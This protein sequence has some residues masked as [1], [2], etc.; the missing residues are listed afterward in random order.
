MPIYMDRHDVPEKITAED[1]AQLHQEDL[2]IQD[3]FNCRVL[4][5]WFD[6]KRKNAFCLV[7][8]PDS[9]A[10]HEMHNHAHGEVPNRIIEVDA[11]IVE[12]F[13]G[14]IE[15]PEKEKNETLNIIREGAFRI[16]MVI[17]FKRSSPLQNADENFTSSL[18]HFS[19]KITDTL[20]AN[21]GKIVTQSSYHYL[22]SFT[23]ASN[24][25]H[26]ATGIQSLFK[27]DAEHN[28]ELKIGL[29][30]GLP[31]TKQPS[32]FEDAIKLAGRIC[33]IVKGEIIISSQVKELYENENADALSKA[34]IFSLT[35]ADENFITQ[36]MDYVDACWND[37]NL[38]VDDFSKPVHCSKSQ[39][40]RKL[41]A[42]TG[43]SPNSFIKEYRLKQ[44]LKL[45]NNNA[46]NISEIAFETGFSSPSYFSK[47]FQKKYGCMPSQLLT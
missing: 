25:V 2:K 21:D 31:V 41:I 37:I 28:A 22:I 40:Y 16:I 17:A 35:K 39:L 7:E 27:K 4:T 30:A 43:Y 42:L 47:C 20:N 9:N 3:Q 14:R 13:L 24:A 18:K 12:S 34:N 8:A 26:A 19:N 33:E 15:D 32:F 6:E 10:I 1:I 38:Q 11:S 5:Y 46:G 44:A 36:L 23:S 29:S 45:L